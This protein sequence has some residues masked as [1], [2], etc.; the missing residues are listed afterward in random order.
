M[1]IY[2]KTISK[3]VFFLFRT[4]KSNNINSTI[5]FANNSLIIPKAII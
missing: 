3:F 4:Q 1:V 5:K 2:P